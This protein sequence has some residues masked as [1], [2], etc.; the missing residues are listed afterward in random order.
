[1]K[2][3]LSVIFRD[4][5]WAVVSSKNTTVHHEGDERSRTA[6]GH[7]YPAYTETIYSMDYQAFPTEAD[8]LEYLS[9][10]RGRRDVREFLL[11]VEPLEYTFQTVVKRP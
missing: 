10:M 8:A 6:P 5:H 11:R 1:M 7:G 4:L 3:V 2:N 9:V